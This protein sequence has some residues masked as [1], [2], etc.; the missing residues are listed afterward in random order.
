MCAITSTRESLT[1]TPGG[2]T[3]YSS[4]DW[5]WAK[6]ALQTVD[7]PYGP[8]LNLL[9]HGIGSTHVCHHI[10]PKIPHYNAW[11]ASA[12]LKQRFPDLVRYDSTPIHLALWRVATRCTVVSRR[13]IDGGFFYEPI[14][15]N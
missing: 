11:R 10:N 15:S 14:S 13:G 5:N 6:G 9:H 1:T 7:R 8:V 3:P 2:P 4:R 12:L